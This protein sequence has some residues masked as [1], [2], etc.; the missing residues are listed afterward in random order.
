MLS[1]E[2]ISLR[3]LRK[4]DLEFLYKIE[5]DKS[6]WRYGSEKKTYSKD[7]LLTYIENSGIAIKNIK[8]FRFVIDYNDS[9]IGFIDLFDYNITEVSIGLI[10]DEKYRSRGFS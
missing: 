8:Q 4:S 10:I 2:P 9:A 3:F 5:N 6:L 1:Q 7:E